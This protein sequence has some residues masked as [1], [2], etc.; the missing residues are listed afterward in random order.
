MDQ[1]DTEVLRQL[2]RAW[3]AGEDY[4]QGISRYKAV[5]LGSKKNDVIKC[6]K[7][8]LGTVFSAT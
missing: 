5:Y 7:N 4:W 2:I 6:E 8:V 3:G 1:N